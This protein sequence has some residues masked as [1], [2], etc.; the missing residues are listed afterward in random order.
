MLSLEARPQFPA[1]AET[2][3]PIEGHA[4]CLGRLSDRNRSEIWWERVSP[5]RSRLNCTIPVNP[6]TLPLKGLRQLYSL[7]QMN[8]GN[9]LTLQVGEVPFLSPYIGSLVFSE[10]LQPVLPSQYRRLGVECLKIIVAHAGIHANEA[11]GDYMECVQRS[12]IL[13]AFSQN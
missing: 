2:T 8:K 13:Q 5:G 10:R 12:A 1:L 3:A 11:P 9:D 4:F 6:G 7:P